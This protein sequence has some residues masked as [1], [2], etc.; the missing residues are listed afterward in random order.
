[1]MKLFQRKIPVLE[2]NP[3]LSFSSCFLLLLGSEC[4][5]IAFFSSESK[6]NNKRMNLLWLFS[7]R[8]SLF[9]VNFGGKLNG[10][11]CERLESFSACE[12]QYYF[13]S[14]AKVIKREVM[15]G[16]IFRILVL[17]TCIASARSRKAEK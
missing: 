9:S 2:N 8:F 7:A 10:N 11:R 5:M 14:L 17:Q 4:I 3:K 15:T 16:N 1:M 6:N 13:S 12:L